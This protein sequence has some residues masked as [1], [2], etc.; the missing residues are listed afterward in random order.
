MVGRTQSREP[1]TSDAQP[2]LPEVRQPAESST[3]GA[4]LAKD[5]LSTGITSAHVALGPGDHLAITV[6][7]TPELSQT[8]RVNSEG[9]ITLALVGEMSVE[10]MSP[11]TLANSIRLRL[12]DGHFMKDPQVSVFVVEYAG[13]MAY[14]AGEVTRPG[15]YPLLRA[16]R[17]SDLLSFAGGLTSRAGDTVTIVRPGSPAG[18]IH[19]DLKG[20]DLELRNPEVLPGDS[21]TVGRAGIVYVLG[22]VGRPGGFLLDRR[23]T[24]SVMQALALAEGVKPSAALTKAVLVHT[25]A[26]GRQESALNLKAILKSQAP[27]PLVQAG[28]LIIVPS[29]LIHGMGRRSIEILEDSAGLA[30]I[31]AGRP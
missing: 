16:H 14:V 21:I 18:D 11:D 1:G 10:G 7:D 5:A 6:F 13:Q 2:A 27:D 31:Y 4:S 29:S 26:A 20:T 9:R 23:A 15:A 22:D 3:A 12:I 8:V 24:T 30:G 17:L 19:V 28:D 25:S